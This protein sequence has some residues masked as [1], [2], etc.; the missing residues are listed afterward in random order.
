MIKAI[1]Y[2]VFF[3][4]AIINSIIGFI[5]ADK[6]IDKAIEKDSLLELWPSGL[7]IIFS[8]LLGRVVRALLKLN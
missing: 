2:V 7:H 1:K 6:T 8:L 4:V 5:I 3:I